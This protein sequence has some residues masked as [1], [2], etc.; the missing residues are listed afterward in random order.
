[1]ENNQIKGTLKKVYCSTMVPLETDTLF[2]LEQRVDYM[3]Q[4]MCKTLIEELKKEKFIKE[5]TEIKDG[6]ELI[7]MKLL[8]YEPEPNEKY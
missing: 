7:K 1:M 5:E 4:E 6:Y 3:K 8:V 2:P